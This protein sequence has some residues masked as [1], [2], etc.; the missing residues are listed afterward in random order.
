MAK[1]MTKK[2]FYKKFGKK[3]PPYNFLD[4]KEMGKRRM[5]FYNYN[6][7]FKK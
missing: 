3:P 4:Q 1:K 7:L 2:E 6:R 5:W